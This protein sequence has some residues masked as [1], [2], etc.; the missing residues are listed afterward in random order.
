[1]PGLVGAEIANY[2]QAVKSIY[3]Q[4]W[5]TPGEV[6]DDSATVQ[7]KIV[8]ARDGAVIADTIVKKSGIPALD[9]SVQDAL[10]R[11]RSQRLLPAFPD[12][13]MDGQRTFFINFNLKARRL[14]G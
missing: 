8:V 4:A 14:N 11:V 5:I 1:M 6:S 12:G 10:D 2:G 7:V 9:K 13:A 3:D